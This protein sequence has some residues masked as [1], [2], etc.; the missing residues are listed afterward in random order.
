[1]IGENTIPKVRPS[2]AAPCSCKEIDVPTV[3]GSAMAARP[4]SLEKSLALCSNSPSY[5]A[6]VPLISCF[7]YHL[8]PRPT[9]DLIKRKQAMH[10][11]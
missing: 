6:A 8:L 3:A 10:H 9:G 5:P 7:V 4:G 1:M 2:I 11:P